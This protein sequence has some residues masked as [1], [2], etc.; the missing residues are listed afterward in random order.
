[1]GEVMNKGSSWTNLGKLA[2]LVAGAGLLGMGEAQAQAPAKTKLKKVLILDKSQFGAGGHMESRRDL[3]LALAAL[4]TEKGFAVTTIS[5]TDPASKIATEFSAANLAAYQAVIFS[6]NDGVH[7]QL[8]ATEKTNLEAYVKNGGGFIPVHA[9]SAFIEN[10]S[11]I[12]GAL[13]E[14]FYGPHGSNQPTAN[15]IHDA[16]GIKDETETKG[17][18]KGLTAPLAFLDEYYSFRASPRGKPGVT[19][20]LRVDEGTFSKPVNGPMGA[21]HPVVWSKVDGK[22]RIV[23]LSMGHSWSTNNVYT[24]KNNYLKNFLYGA[25][26]YAAGDFFGCTDANKPGYNPDATKNDP[27]ACNVISAAYI[28]GAQG[29]A[30][31]SRNQG[32]SD[33]RVV[34]NASGRHEVEILDVSGRPV[35]SRRGEKATEYSLPLPSRS[36]IYVVV[37]RAGGQETRHRVTVL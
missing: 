13:V 16:D 25:L 11:W 15:V 1:M 31:I 27:D 3:N 10:W 23:H 18:F 12:T 34:I 17:I 9:A 36:G 14:S 19:V 21:D 6:N 26:R 32:E 22:G 33:I 4:A 7:A 8:S 30:L 24:A 2:M 29:R 37:A 5:Q 35:E 28:P 20:L